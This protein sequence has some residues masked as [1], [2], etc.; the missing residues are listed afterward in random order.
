MKKSFYILATLLVAMQMI[1]CLKDSETTGSPECAITL[2]SVADIPCKR[3]ITVNGVDSTIKVSMSGKEIYFNIDQLNRKIYNV[4]SLPYWV[5]ITK[6]VPT[7]T[8][9]GN[10]YIRGNDE[11]FH[12]FNNGKDSID[13]TQKIQFMVVAYDGVSRKIYD[14]DIRLASNDADS[15]YWTAEEQTAPMIGKHH[16]VT[17]DD[18]LYVFHEVNGQ[19]Y[20]TSTA[21]DDKERS[22]TTPQALTGAKGTINYASVLYFDGYFYALDNN[23]I[24]YRSLTENKALTWEQASNRLLTKLLAADDNYLYGC[25]DDAIWASSEMKEWIMSGSENLGLVPEQYGSYAYYTT[26]TNP[27]FQNVVMMGWNANLNKDA[28]VWYKL[29]SSNPDDDQEW[30]YIH[31]NNDNNYEMPKLRDLQMV[32][33]NGELMAFGGEKEGETST[34]TAYNAIYTSNDNGITWHKQSKKLGL[35]KEL[36]GYAGQVTATV[37]NGKIW[38]VRDDGKVWSGIINKKSKRSED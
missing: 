11:P 37:A 29:S 10:V 18:I 33:Y 3:I 8:C 23:N 28:V 25:D 2:F 38:L 14:A 5:T 35:P 6:V 12:A 7:V 13:F 30:E 32:Y 22:W 19:A 17:H 15:L 20:V 9:Q 21:V 31:V 34:S 4:D 1:S 36:L 27:N 26:K 24:L 16:N